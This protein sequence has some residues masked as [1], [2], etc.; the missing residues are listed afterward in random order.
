MAYTRPTL[1]KRPQLGANQVYLMANGDLRLSAN[2]NC[3]K[4]KH[5]MEQA[6]GKAVEAAG[7]SVVSAHPYKQD[8]K[9]GFIG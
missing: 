7:W 3:W 9:H 1:S 6:I 2:Q 4:A 5:E 8:E